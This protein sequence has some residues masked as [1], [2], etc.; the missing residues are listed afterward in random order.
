[1]STDVE[2]GE[3]V[4]R[5]RL[6]QA[7]GVA[8]IMASA[9]GVA[10]LAVPSKPLTLG[11]PPLN[12]EAQ[13]P[14]TF[15]DWRIDTSVAPLV[16]DPTLEAS[17]RATYDQNIARTY[18]NSKGERV[19]LTI[20]YGADQSAEATQ[21]HRPEIC[22]GAQ[23]FVI[24]AKRDEHLTLSGHGVPVRRLFATLGLRKEP[25]S[26]WVTLG[27]RTSLPG[28]RRKLEQIRIGLSGRYADGVLMRVS[29]IGEDSQDSFALHDRFLGDLYVSVHPDV[30]PRYFGA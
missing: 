16:A 4:D 7:L 20:A 1:M 26:Y 25:V 18:M 19:M 10:H 5:R 22:Y 29:N 15:A 14:R 11:Y 21:V 28:F 8:A 12:V 30:R 2:S 24:S 23:G 3:S 27:D 9:P 6:L 13:I 17:V